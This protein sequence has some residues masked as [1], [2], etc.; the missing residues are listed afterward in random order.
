MSKSIYVGNLSYDA[1]SNDLMEFFKT[2]G[3]DPV[4][5]NIVT[6]RETGRSRGFAFVDFGD[7]ATAESARSTLDGRSL[8][9]REIRLDAARERAPRGSG[10]GGGG[11]AGGANRGGFAG[12][13]NRG[14]FAGAGGGDG[15]WG[16][17]APSR[18]G[19]RG[20]RG[21][22]RNNSRRERF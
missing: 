5:A 14:G 11:F 10:G 3:F 19:D 9:G 15:G 4:R 22:R 12:G 7:D 1:S 13:A 6:D 16:G 20:E 17:D 18:G 8:L 2:G 21:D